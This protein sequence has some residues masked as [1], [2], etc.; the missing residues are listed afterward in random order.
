M[1]K[2]PGIFMY[3]AN[4]YDNL[5]DFELKY[6]SMKTGCII[7]STFFFQLFWDNLKYF[8]TF[9]QMPQI[10]LSFLILKW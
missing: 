10:I 5:K 1:Y 7:T 9:K 6:S 8:E 2:V 3:F 4:C